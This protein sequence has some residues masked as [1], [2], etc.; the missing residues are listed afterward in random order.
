MTQELEEA[1]HA[2]P[3][4]GGAQV[5]HVHLLGDVGGGEIHHHLNAT[6]SSAKSQHCFYCKT[7]PGKVSPAP[8]KVSPAPFHWRGNNQVIRTIKRVVLTNPLPGDQ[9]WRF[10]SV[11]QQ[12]A[13]QF[14]D[15]RPLQVDV[16]EA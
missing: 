3:D 14:G 4:D 2:F 10:D 7:E 8:G 13:Q 1:A 12:L 15:K 16:D 5:T 11:N 9:R 6:H